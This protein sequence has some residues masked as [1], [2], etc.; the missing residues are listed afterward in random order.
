MANHPTVAVDSIA[1]SG[2]KP[3]SFQAKPMVTRS[4]TILGLLGLNDT[5]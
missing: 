1:Q 3:T 2:S 4:L 5:N